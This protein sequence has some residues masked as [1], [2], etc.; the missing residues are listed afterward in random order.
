[1]AGY[2]GSTNATGAQN[3]NF[4][5]AGGGTVATQGN[6]DCFV[7]K[8]DE[9]GNYQWALGLGNIGQETQ[10]RAWDISTDA[11]GNSYVVG[12]FHGTVN[13]N[14][15]GTA[16]NYILPNALVGLFIA[17]YNT[18]GICQWVVML[19]AQC[20]SVFTEGYATCDLD[21][22]GNLYVAGNFRGSNVN[23]NPLGTP[24]SLSSNGNTDIFIGK[25]NT[26]DGSLNWVKQIG[27]AAT[28]IVSPGALRCDNHGNPYFTGRLS[29]T[30]TVDFDPSAAVMSV[31]N[32]AL[33]LTSYDA[34]G[35][36][37]Y[38]TGMGSGACDGGHRVAF[39]SSYNVYLTGWM[40]GTT[41]F[42]TITRT[43]NSTT[44][45]V[46]LA[47]Y[48]ND[49]STC[50]WALNF[51]GAGSTANSICAALVIDHENNPILTG[52]LYGIGANVNPLSTPYNL[53]SVGNNDCFVIKYNSNGT[54][55]V[56]SLLPIKLLSFVGVCFDKYNVLKWQTSTEINSKYFD[57]ERSINGRTF[58]RIATVSA[59][60][61]SSTIKDYSF[62]DK[63]SGSSFY[64]RLKQ[65]DVDGKFEYSKIILIKN[66]NAN[67][68]NVIVFPNP[69][70]NL[71][72]ISNYSSF[73]HYSIY[74]TAG[75]ECLS[76][77]IKRQINISS[78]CK[79]VYQIILRNNNNGKQ[80]VKEIIKQ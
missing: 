35:N 41:T 7:A 19:D 13:F 67:V 34:N 75:V 32:S 62:T 50:L 56:N 51:G 12:G 22:S 21:N 59:A 78:L 26:N 76:G 14:L 64:Y 39:D 18:N 73:T 48:T 70:Y 8:Y 65:V 68:E 77:N 28:E 69:T 43:A 55:W 10:E 54:L 9:N 31:S 61:N 20:T 38:A 58:K 33:Y 25:Y 29:G 16:M 46:F 2:F 57:V 80:T 44:A 66:A 23:F 30:N 17:K 37:R 11:V 63:V 36:L 42:G 6:E 40:N 5:P 79:G 52:Q 3:A 72:I 60:G 27:T 1:M 74:N 71:I 45:D 49:L 24:N 4:N 53:S 47:K 15:L